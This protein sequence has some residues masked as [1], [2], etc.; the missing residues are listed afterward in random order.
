MDLNCHKLSDEEIHQHIMRIK[1][2]GMT[3]NKE[4]DKLLESA[5][6]EKSINNSLK[7]SR[8]GM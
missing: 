4:L 5:C 8:I 1:R 6:K 2:R 3:Y 7:G